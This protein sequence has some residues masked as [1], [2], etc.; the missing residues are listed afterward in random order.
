M[1]NVYDE[2]QITNALVL[3]ITRTRSFRFWNVVRVQ[4]KI[5]VIGTART[6]TFA[7]VNS[8]FAAL[9]NFPKFNYRSRLNSSIIFVASTVHYSKD[10]TVMHVRSILR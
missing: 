6:T 8:N 1:L 5:L 9:N 2:F 4:F 10:R 7:K 3:L